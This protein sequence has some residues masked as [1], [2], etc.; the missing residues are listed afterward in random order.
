MGSTKFTSLQIHTTL[1]QRRS[2]E[3]R[4]VSY[5]TWPQGFNYHNYS[6]HVSWSRLAA[7][8]CPQAWRAAIMSYI[9]TP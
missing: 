5:C 3:N 7:F 1:L 8:A 6:R 2:F 9:T 4:S